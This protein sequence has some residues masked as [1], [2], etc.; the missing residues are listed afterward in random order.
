MNEKEHFQHRAVT[1]LQA[2]LMVNGGQAVLQTLPTVRELVAEKPRRA[3]VF[4]KW[5]IPYCCCIGDATVAQA[6]RARDIEPQDVFA[7]LRAHDSVPPVPRHALVFWQEAPLENLAWHIANEHFP[8]VRTELSRVSYLVDRVAQKHG[9]LYPE[10]WE[11][12]ALFEEFKG[13]C[14]KHMAHQESALFP[15]LKHLT[16][17]DHL[18]L[19]NVLRNLRSELNYLQATLGVLRERTTGFAAPANACNTYRVLL[20]ALEELDTELSS[21]LNPEEEM[22]F[23]R[24]LETNLKT[25]L[26]NE[27]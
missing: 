17:V 27:T 24:A 10:L 20:D 6:C 21:D 7:D 15:L 4:E 22:L 12:Q 8:F 14:D 26:R 9:E 13:E 18:H 5:G 1:R 23:T 19:E 2:Q 25:Q 3:R 16:T 11:L